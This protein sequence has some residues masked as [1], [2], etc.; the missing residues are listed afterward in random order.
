MNLQPSFQ[1]PLLPLPN[2]RLLLYLEWMLLGLTTLTAIMMPTQAGLPSSPTATI[3]CIV[4]FGV[5]GLKLPRRPLSKLLYTVAEF[6]IILLPYTSLP[7]GLDGRSRFVS[8][9]GVIIVMRGCQMF[10]LPGRLMIAALVF[11]VF[12]GNMFMRNPEIFFLRRVANSVSLPPLETVDSSLI[13]FLKLNSVISLGLA[14]IFVLLLV[15]A[16]ISERQSRQELAIAHDQLRQYALRIENQATLQ[17]RNRIARDIHDSVGH[18]L[19]AQKIQFKNALLFWR[20]NLEQAKE[21]VMEAKQLG[22]QALQE[23]SHSV[24][25][26]RVE[27]LR[28]K[29]LDTAIALLLQDFQHNTHLQPNCAIH[30]AAPLSTEIKI[31]LYR[32]LQEALT[33]IARH[34]AATQV[35]VQLNTQANTLYLLVA[36]NG[37]GFCP[38]QN[39]TGFGLQSMR[40]RAI[41]L[42]GRLHILSVLGQGCQIQAI[43]PISTL[44]PKLISL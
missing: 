37:R 30:L 29:S 9:L 11:I 24:A 21:Y 35:T 41:A 16:L 33:N 22:Y 25:T 32:I 31:A 8:S 3:G 20:S 19:T 14:V 2:L 12:I 6:A 7:I 18:A 39:T 42:G 4:L 5:M 15:N 17:E 44:S 28:D 34:S 10:Q 1:K 26:L 27:P 38:N 36:D 40:E 43:V 23:V 13:L